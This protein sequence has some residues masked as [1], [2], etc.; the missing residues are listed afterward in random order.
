MY[1]RRL[2]LLW[3]SYFFGAFFAKFN[4]IKSL[5]GYQKKEIIIIL[6]NHAVFLSAKEFNEKIK[7]LITEFPIAYRSSFY[8]LHQK[9]FISKAS[10]QL[11]SV[12]QMKV[13][14]VW[15]S[16]VCYEKWINSNECKSLTS[17]LK[18]EGFNLIRA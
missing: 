4:I 3:L 12:N 8:K 14:R 11:L 13:E 1:S 17:L 15:Q 10:R 16:N 7:Q 6:S 2:F 5:S 18:N 9:G